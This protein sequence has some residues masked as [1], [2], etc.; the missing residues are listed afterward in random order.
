M[1]Y[2]KTLVAMSFLGLAGC[3]PI[4]ID[5]GHLP[6]QFLQQAKQFEGRYVGSFEGKKAEIVLFL[7]GD[8]PILKY[9]DQDS[10][11][12]LGTECQSQIGLLRTISVENKNGRESLG[13]MEFDFNPGACLKVQG[14][15]VSLRSFKK[16]QFSLRILDHT[17][18][19]E[20]C[21]P[22]FPPPY[23]GHRCGQQEVP[24]YREGF[25]TKYL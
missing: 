14:R 17:E 11:D 21:D 1:F 5:G 25:F 8:Q 7:R 16:T 18:M 12:L 20:E 6:K 9:K 3:K 24:V 2:L 4:S 10:D 22:R 23:E 19:E 13:Q 15:R